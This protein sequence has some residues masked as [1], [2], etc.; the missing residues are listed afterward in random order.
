MDHLK[1]TNGSLKKFKPYFCYNCI[2]IIDVIAIFES[3]NS[4]RCKID[5][6]SCN[7][8]QKMQ[9]KNTASGTLLLHMCHLFIF[10][11]CK[12]KIKIVLLEKGLLSARI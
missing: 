1:V 4:S 11:S 9:Q 8:I 5:R 6:R 3:D 7:C 2:N 12:N 10:M